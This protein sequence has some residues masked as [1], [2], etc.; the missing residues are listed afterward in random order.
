MIYSVYK[1]GRGYDYYE[2]PSDGK[3]HAGTPPRARAAAM[4]G[5]T[6]E[7]A[8]W[9]VPAGAKHVGSGTAP[10]GR[11]ASMGDAADAIG[12]STLFMDWNSPAYWVL[13]GL[14]IYLALRRPR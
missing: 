4:L 12:F 9:K 13:A 8:A 14:G 1:Y 10:R 3:T 7:Q 2:G 6:P 11:I 5:A